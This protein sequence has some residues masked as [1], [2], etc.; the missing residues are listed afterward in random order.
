MIKQKKMYFQ[1]TWKIVKTAHR[2]I[3]LCNLFPFFFHLFLGCQG[4][5]KLWEIQ[6]HEINRTTFILDNSFL[7]KL[8]FKNRSFKFKAHWLLLANIFL[9]LFE[10]NFLGVSRTLGMGVKKLKFFV[11][12]EWLSSK[13]KLIENAKNKLILF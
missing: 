6:R 11:L 12:Y 2:D 3:S 4:K 1:Y 8:Q 9:I 5:R 7:L 13:L 10:R